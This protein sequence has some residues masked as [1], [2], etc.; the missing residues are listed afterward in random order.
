M[1]AIGLAGNIVGEIRSDGTGTSNFFL[2][3]PT[4]YGDKL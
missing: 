1:L 2:L 4:N 3:A